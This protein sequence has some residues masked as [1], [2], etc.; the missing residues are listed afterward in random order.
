MTENFSQ[1]LNQSL[2]NINIKPGSLIKGIVVSIDKDY[3][4]IDAGLKSES[5]I[6]IEQFKNTRGDL[7]VKI[8]QEIDLILD[9]VE[10]GF[11]ET[12]LSREKAKKHESWL[13]LEKTYKKSKT[14]IGIIN[15][16][17]KGG[18]TVEINGIRAFLPGSLVDV[19][20]IHETI[21]LEGKELEFKVIKLDKKRNNVVVSRK[22]VISFE[23]KDEKENLIKNLREDIEIKGIVKNL[24][25]Y[26]AF[27]DLGGIDGLL[28]ITDM[29]WKRVKHPSEI[30]K[31]GDEIFVKILKFDKE[32]S[33]VSLGLKQLTKDP[34][35]SI[36]EKYPEG[37]KIKG[38]ITNLTDYGCFVEIKEGVEGLVHISEMDWTNKNVNSSKMVNI[39]E[40]VEVMILNIDEERRRISLG[41]K[42][43]KPN[44]WKK[45]SENHKKGD[46][47]KGKIKSITD[48]G[49]FIGLENGVDGLVHLSDVSWDKNIESLQK[50]KKGDEIITAVLQ[51]DFE[52]E[53]I[54]LGIKQLTEDPIIKYISI[55]KKGSMVSGIIKQINQKNI[56]IQLTEQVQGKAKIPEFLLKNDGKININEYF[57]LNDKIKT[58]YTGI[59]KKN[60]IILLSIKIKDKTKEKKN[61]KMEKKEKINN[62]KN[63]IMAEAFKAAKNE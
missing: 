32:K 31:I 13:I 41:L 2:E 44:P 61:N 50:Y 4:L 24:T 14:I 18:F 59:D 28:H 9:T 17:V 53:R 30:V 37:T 7:E 19:R 10:D 38:K 6:P 45:F 15:G 42:Q 63:N 23:N 51:V 49:I 56:I 5:S 8:G 48:F 11:G 12:L 62:I 58:K 1:L 21:H 55:N 33:R 29:A 40:I 46:H 27:I 47:V 39:N 25:D 36:K 34:W 20:P 26:G 57:N 22:A 3:V 60:R 43:C 16:K 52:R 54:S 35:M